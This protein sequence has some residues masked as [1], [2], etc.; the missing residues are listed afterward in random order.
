MQRH[1]QVQ[2]QLQAQTQTQPQLQPQAQWHSQPQEQ[3]QF[4]I[5]TQPQVPL[6]VQM[7]VQPQVQAWTKLDP[8]GC[9]YCCEKHVN[10]VDPISMTCGHTICKSCLTEVYVETGE[11]KCYQCE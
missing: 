4:P 11:V 7:Q 10:L 2:A 3:L 6:Q 1:M 5:H 8:G 9:V